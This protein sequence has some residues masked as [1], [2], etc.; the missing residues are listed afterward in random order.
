MID[1]SELASEIENAYITI[2]ACLGDLDELVVERNMLKA[3]FECMGDAVYYTDPEWRIQGWNRVAEELTGYTQEEVMGLRCRD[4][5]VHTDREGKALCDQNCPLMACANNNQFVKFDEVWLG[6]KDGKRIPVDVSCAMVKDSNGNTLGLVEVFR[7]RTKHLEL[8]H[9]K[10]EFTAAITHDLK[11]PITA[12][13]GFTELL[14]DPRFGDISEKKLEY[15]KLIR[16]SN[17]ML[18]NLVGNIVDSARIEVG[19]MHFD[20]EHI[21]LDIILKELGDTFLPL[22]IRAQITIDY[23]CSEN[24]WVYADRIKLMQVFHNLI[25]NSLRYTPKGG[26]IS[27]TAME[28]GE[29]IHFIVKDT[30]LGIPA[31][32]HGKLF[33][34]FAQMKGGHRSTGLGLYIVKNILKGHNSDIT[35]QSEPG[36]GTSFFFSVAK[37]APKERII[38]RAGTLLLVGEDTES[39]RLI[40]HAMIKVGHTLEFTESGMEGLQKLLSLKPDLVLLHRPLPDMEVD[41]FHYAVITNVKTKDIPV[42]LL[43]PIVLPEWEKRFSQIVLLPVNIRTLKEAVQ[44]VLFLNGGSASAPQAEAYPGS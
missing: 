23:T 30:G 6:R 24:T 1:D 25:S 38:V 42:I 37:G 9:M 15:V 34:K 36:K 12:M 39:A 5:L 28:E 19:Q 44:K 8:M 32:E 11:S 40:R 14:L 13:M 31:N 16:Q 41:D 43:A 20:F 3:V 26:T 18:M 10:E 7:D 2:D 22:A 33:Q 29:R 21:P 17:N 35:F 4:L 27:I